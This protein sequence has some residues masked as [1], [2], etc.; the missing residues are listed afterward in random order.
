VRPVRKGMAAPGSGREYMNLNRQFHFIVLQ[1]GPKV[2]DRVCCAS[3]TYLVGMSGRS[4][5]L[6]LGLVI[7]NGGAPTNHEADDGEPVR[8]GMRDLTESS[9]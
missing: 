8:V 3:I 2:S 1:P 5:Y 4:L 7:S 9:R 6:L